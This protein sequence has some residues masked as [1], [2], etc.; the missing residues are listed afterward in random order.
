MAGSSLVS[1]RVVWLKS[2]DK[3]SARS[4]SGPMTW[5][6]RARYCL[7]LSRK[8]RQALRKWLAF[9][10]ASL[11]SGQALLV[12]GRALSEFCCCW[13]LLVGCWWTDLK[14]FVAEWST[15][16]SSVHCISPR[17]VSRV[18]DISGFMLARVL[19]WSSV[20]YRCFR[21]LGSYGLMR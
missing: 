4:L 5:W 17:S 19:L 10:L 9:C 15:W 14:F 1:S 20:P 6:D 12:G 7:S 8:K 13:N 16:A 3:S 2:E 21:S 18:S 11:H